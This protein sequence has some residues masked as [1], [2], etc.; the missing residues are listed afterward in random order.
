MFKINRKIEYAL[1]S[2]KYM[3]RKS[4]GQLT[5]AKEI[6]DAY[7]T[8]FDPTSRVLQLMAQKGILHA[9]Q[10]A[11]GG[12]QIIKDLTKINVGD[13]S[14][15]IVGPI[16]ITDCMHGNYSHCGLT[17]S[18]NVIAPMLNLNE[19]I[20]EIFHQVTVSELLEAKHQGERQ[21]REKPILE[22]E[23]SAKAPAANVGGDLHG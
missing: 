19:K 18:C 8:P 5:S 4:P 13:L 23:T 16:K 6:C 3:S 9:E 10:G 14:D 21:I 15:I 2:L 11:H 22:K 17:S 7:H 20:S 1:V 12:Y